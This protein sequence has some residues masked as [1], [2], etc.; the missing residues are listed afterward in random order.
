MSQSGYSLRPIGTWFDTMFLTVLNEETSYIKEDLSNMIEDYKSIND[1]C[2]E[3][4]KSIEVYHYSN[5]QVAQIKK[6]ANSLSTL[7]ETIN[8][9]KNKL[10]N[11]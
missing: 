7:S 5:S 2:N 3:T 4:L 6:F 9:L 11:L 10:N 8:L 1:F